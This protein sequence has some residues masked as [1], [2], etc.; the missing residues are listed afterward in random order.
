MVKKVF[1]VV[2]IIL[3]LSTF[4]LFTTPV[5][6]LSSEPIILLAD[7]PVDTVEPPDVK[8]TVEGAD[9]FLSEGKDGSGNTINFDMLNDTSNVM[10]NIL[11]VVGICAAAIIAAVLGIQFIT[12]SVEQKV[13]VKEALIPFVIGC[14]VLFGAFGIWRLIII[15]LR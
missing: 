3:F 6:A 2:S 11:L 8:N 13:K 4:F 14:A 5:Q 1:L 15:L 9:D 7:E 10:Y 12:G